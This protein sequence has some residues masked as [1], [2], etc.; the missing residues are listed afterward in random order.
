MCHLYIIQTADNK[1]IIKSRCNGRNL[2]ALDSANHNYGE[3]LDVESYKDENLYMISCNTG[4]E[5]QYDENGL[6]RCVIKNRLE[7]KIF[8]LCSSAM[9]TS[10]Q[11]CLISLTVT[12]KVKGDLSMFRI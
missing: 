1:I 10:A 5:M 9:I 7:W 2:Q 11:L 3:K 8:H 6:A 12:T 4:D